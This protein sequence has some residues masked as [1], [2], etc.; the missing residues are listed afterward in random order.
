M[1]RVRS[2]LVDAVVRIVHLLALP[3]QLEMKVQVSASSQALGGCDNQVSHHIGLMGET[4]LHRWA[5]LRASPYSVGQGKPCM[6]RSINTRRW[7][8]PH[9]GRWQENLC[10]ISFTGS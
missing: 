10:A 3:S 4:V 7:K 5:P 6:L 2:E 8:H 1:E 9:A